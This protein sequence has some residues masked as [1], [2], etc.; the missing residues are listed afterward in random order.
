MAP[1]PTPEKRNPCRSA[2]FSLVELLAVIGI[3]GFM[4]T[5]LAPAIGTLAFAGKFSASATTLS[6]ALDEARAY[7][8]SKR[9]YVYVGIDEF[10][11]SASLD[12]G[13]PGTGRVALFAAASKEGTRIAQASDFISKAQLISGLVRLDNT[14]L[15]NITDTNGGLQRPADDSVKMLGPINGGAGLNFPL[16]SA[17]R[18]VC[19]RVIEF[20]PQG[21]IRAFGAAELPGFLE[22]GMKPSR[23]DIV[24]A[25]TA[26]MAV[27]QLSGLTG[28]SALY[29][30]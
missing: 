16:S 21:M 28:K 13:N 7:A 19:K 1:G 27:V 5:L 26:N 23:G 15:E 11:A 2:A 12:Q 8:V 30:P 24:S 3:I 17:P 4:T 18:Y 29:R 10:Q 9:T 14:H 22:I 20:S 25:K 6:E